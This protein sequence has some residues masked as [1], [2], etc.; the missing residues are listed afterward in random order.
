[1][2]ASRTGAL[3]PFKGTEYIGQ[4]MGADEGRCE[5]KDIK[6]IHIMEDMMGSSQEQLLGGWLRLLAKD[7]EVCGDRKEQAGVTLGKIIDLHN[8]L[9]ETNIFRHCTWRSPYL[10]N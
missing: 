1:M 10:F 5:G 8:V 2:T 7:S 6:R 9:T 4:V 3:F